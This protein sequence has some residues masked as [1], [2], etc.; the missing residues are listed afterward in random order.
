MYG[1]FGDC[2]LLEQL[3]MHYISKEG[4]S[5]VHFQLFRSMFLH[6]VTVEVTWSPSAHLMN[7]VSS[8]DWFDLVISFHHLKQILCAY[9]K[10]TLTFISTSQMKAM[11]VDSQ[12]EQMQR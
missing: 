3:V 1:L 8:S 11:N 5:N 6:R 2:W 7:C 10:L 9:K 12:R 4:E